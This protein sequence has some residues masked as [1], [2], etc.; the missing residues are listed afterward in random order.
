MPSLYPLHNSSKLN[1]NKLRG[2]R[3]SNTSESTVIFAKNHNDYSGRG[4]ARDLVALF[5]ITLICFCA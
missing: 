2:S 5:Y 4:S 1:P 3:R